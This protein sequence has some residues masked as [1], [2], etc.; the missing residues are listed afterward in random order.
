MRP[1]YFQCYSNLCYYVVHEQTSHLWVTN[2]CISSATSK[3]GRVVK[4]RKG[5]QRRANWAKSNTRITAFR[6]NHLFSHEM[7]RHYRSVIQLTEGWRRAGG[8]GESIRASLYLWTINQQQSILYIQIFTTTGIKI[9]SR[10]SL[11][12]TRDGYRDQLPKFQ[13]QSWRNFNF[14]SVQNNH[15]LACE[16]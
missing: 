15:I 3:P 4:V 5:I 10:N 2:Q 9:Q 11:H 1:V 7:A 16:V 13:F 8:T 12:S 14:S 6:N